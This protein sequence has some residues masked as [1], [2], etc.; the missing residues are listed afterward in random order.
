MPYRWGLLFKRLS[1]PCYISI[2]KEYICSFLDCL[3]LGITLYMDVVRILRKP[4]IRIKR[5][6][7]KKIKMFS[8]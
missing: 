1:F 2:L 4:E 6:V 5:K 3:F 7:F 8:I